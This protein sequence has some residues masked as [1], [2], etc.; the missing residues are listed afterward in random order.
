M[1]DSRE[2]DQKVHILGIMGTRFLRVREGS[3][4]YGEGQNLSEPCS[5]VLELRSVSELMTFNT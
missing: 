5:V 2:S 1:G 3:Y 4:N